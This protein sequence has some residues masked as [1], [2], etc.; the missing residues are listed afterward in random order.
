MADLK[1][2]ACNAIEEA[3]SELHALSDDIWN[4][5]ELGFQ[6]KHAHDVLTQFL[7]DKGLQASFLY[8]QA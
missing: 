2:I 6:E 7:K 4:H 1:K 3:A 8:P 5:P